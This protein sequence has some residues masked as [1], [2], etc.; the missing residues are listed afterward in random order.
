[1]MYAA[2][3]FKA[4]AA[5]DAGSLDPARLANYRKLNTERDAAA[6]VL[7]ARQS[8]SSRGSTPGKWRSR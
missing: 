4:R 6:Q 2:R 5:L 3:A 8:A 7:G 1:M